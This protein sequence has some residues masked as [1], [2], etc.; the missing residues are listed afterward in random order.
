M[1]FLLGRTLV[2][3]PCFLPP[4]SFPAQNLVW[5]GS[6][7]VAAPGDGTWNTTAGNNVWNNGVGTAGNASWPVA[8]TLTNAIF[9]RRE[10]RCLRHFHWRKGH[11]CL[12]RLVSK[13]RL[14][15]FPLRVRRSSPVASSSGF[16]PPQVQVA[17]GKTNVI[18]ANGA[19]QSSQSLLVGAY[20]GN[21]GGTLILTTG[22]GIQEISSGRNLAVDGAG[23]IVRVQ[24]GSVFQIT[25][26]GGGNTKRWVSASIPV[27][28]RR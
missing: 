13:F 3:L 25:S 15:P 5:T 2:A 10:G 17:S 1:S 14:H 16:T 27:P 7:T 20:A 12:Q 21:P 19:L 6:G 11:H 24:T 18:G 28:V 22:G 4:R 9:H 8:G 23:T 26:T